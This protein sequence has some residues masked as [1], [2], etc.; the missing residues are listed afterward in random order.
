[1]SENIFSKKCDICGVQPAML[2]FRTF[3]T[4]SSNINEEG[5]CPKCALKKFTEHNNFSIENQ[6]IIQTITQMRHILSDILGHLGKAEQQT[7]TCRFCNTSNMTIKHDKKAGCS[8]CY[9][10]F[11]S[12]IKEQLQYFSSKHCGQIPS[13]YRS[14]YLYSLEL[15]KLKLK[16]QSLLRVENYEE[17][18]KISK[19]ISKLATKQIH[20]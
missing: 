12:L 5:L 18:A 7:K 19:R 20:H 13:R 3:N 11:E 16:L 4:N 15:D 17:A 10:E 6:E 1:M 9:Q 8:Y 2:F 14:Q